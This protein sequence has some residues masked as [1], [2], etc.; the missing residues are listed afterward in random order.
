MKRAIIV[1]C[2]GGYPEYCWYPHTK[3]ELEA[4]GFDVTVPTMPD[5][6][7]PKLSL[8]LPILQQVVGAPSENLYLI[9]HSIGTVTI[10]RYLE[11]L[12]AGQTI[13]GAV[14]VAGFSDD[15]GFK[16]LSN[17]FERPLDFEAIRTKAYAFTLIHSDDDPYV[18]LRYG[19][20]LKAKLHAKLIVK[21]GMKHF[22]GA[23]DTQKSC[24]SLPAVAE[25]ILTMAP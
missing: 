19:D 24:L 25:T 11:T 10:M 16:E 18:P 9:G 17:F 3:K 7:N 23:F 2:W 6:E 8:W 22:S 5:T 21:H 1:H 15:L 13:A 12:L 4:Q 14:F 20:I